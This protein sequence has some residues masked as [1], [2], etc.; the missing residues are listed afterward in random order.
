MTSVVQERAHCIT[1][2]LNGDGSSVCQLRVHRFTTGGLQAH[3]ILHGSYWEVAVAE[4]SRWYLH[5]PSPAM[6]PG[7][8]AQFRPLVLPSLSLL[9][10]F[11]L[12][13]GTL[14]A[15]P[16]MSAVLHGFPQARPR[17]AVMIQQ[18]EWQDH[19]SRSTPSVFTRT[20]FGPTILLETPRK[21]RRFLGHLLLG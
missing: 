11:L 1:N 13:L 2:D 9:A 19:V 14:P 16:F 5:S 4:G 15:Q 10:N 7:L 8:L 17:L 12:I 6:C 18:M 21:Q 3:Q 20:P